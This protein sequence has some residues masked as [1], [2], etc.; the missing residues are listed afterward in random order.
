MENAWILLINVCILRART[1]L[2]P[3]LLNV[4]EIDYEGVNQEDHGIDVLWSRQTLNY[5]TPNN[6]GVMVFKEFYLWDTY[7]SLDT[8]TRCKYHFI[9]AFG[10]KNKSG[11]KNTTFWYQTLFSTKLSL[12]FS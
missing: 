10:Q 8:A 1:P 12:N 7:W 2:P 3:G 4:S 11:I 5:F 6:L 9:C